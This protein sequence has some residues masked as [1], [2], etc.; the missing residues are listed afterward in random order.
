LTNAARK[1]TGPEGEDDVVMAK[2]ADCIWGGV[3]SDA[4][5]QL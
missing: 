3:A 5:L 1:T 2:V 4:M